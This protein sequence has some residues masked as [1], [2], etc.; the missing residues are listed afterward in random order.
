V[1]EKE[2]DDGKEKKRG[3]R[4]GQKARKNGGAREET[5]KKR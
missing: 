2:R 4:E 3:E 1:Y 5:E